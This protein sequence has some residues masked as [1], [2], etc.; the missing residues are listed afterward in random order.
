MGLKI[1][2]NFLALGLLSRDDLLVVLL[3]T[4]AL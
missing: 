2:Y 4:L 1:G 3:E